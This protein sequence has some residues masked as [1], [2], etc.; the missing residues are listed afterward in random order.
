MVMGAVLVFATLFVVMNLLVDLLT[1]CWT[2]RCGR[3]SARRAV[4]W[5]GARCKP[6][7]P[8]VSLLTGR[9]WPEFQEAGAHRSRAAAGRA[10]R[11]SEAV[12]VLGIVFKPGCKDLIYVHL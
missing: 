9:R 2:P 8:R 7:A 1:P 4:R 6:G 3:C 10:K 11:D 12:P 5:R